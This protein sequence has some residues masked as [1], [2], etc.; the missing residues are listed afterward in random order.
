MTLEPS[1]EFEFQQHD[2]HN[3]RRGVR[4]PDQIVETDRGGPSRFTIR[5]RSPASGSSRRARAVGLAQRDRPLHDRLD[6][7]DESAASVISVA[8]CLIKSLVPAARGSSGEPGTANTSRPCS[9]A[10]AVKRSRAMRGLD[11]DDAERHA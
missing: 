3:G 8:S 1:G 5:A 4:H 7:V 9:A 2:A 6:G 10:M 11:D